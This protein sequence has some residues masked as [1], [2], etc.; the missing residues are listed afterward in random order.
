MHLRHILVPLDF[1]P[2]AEWALDAAMK[3]AKLLQSRLTLLHVV[4]IPPMSDVHAAAY[5]AE[6]EMDAHEGLETY[7]KRIQDAGIPV[8]IRLVR[9]VPFREIVD[10]ARG[11]QADLIIMGIHGRT[12]IPRL[13]LGSVAE[14]VVRLAPCPVMVVCNSA[15]TTPP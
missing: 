8:A 6:I 7:Q 3:F 4:H 9:G 14:R 2:D 13:L 5:V 11:I 15:V 12:G 10:I 1:S